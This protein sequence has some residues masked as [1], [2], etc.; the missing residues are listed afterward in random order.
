MSFMEDP[1]PPEPQDSD[2]PPPATSSEK[3]PRNSVAPSA[4]VVL[5]STD[6]ACLSRLQQG[7]KPITEK[8]FQAKMDRWKKENSEDNPALSDF[9]REKFEVEVMA[10]DADQAN[11]D[12][13]A[14]NI[15]FAVQNKR[16]V[17]NFLPPSRLASARQAEDAPCEEAPA[18]SEEAARLEAAE[19]KK[20]K[21]QDERVE[22]IK[23]EELIRLEKHSEPLRQYL[24]SFVVPTLTSGLIEV[25]HHT[26]PDPV[27]YLA[28]YLSV[29]SHVSR[30]HGKRSE[31]KPA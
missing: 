31:S 3:V 2:T 1:P 26:P 15:A 22:Q 28:E 18:I 14:E 5:S 29:Y 17:Y 12:V 4:V 9:F 7:E 30:T 23:R 27:G 13:E 16:P 11:L 19:L 25:C 10:V 6:D 8:E 20:K 21:E 24:M